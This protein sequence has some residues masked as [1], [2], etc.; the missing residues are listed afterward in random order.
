MLSCAQ[1]E[2]MIS[3]SALL[4]VSHS[5]R[6]LAGP[7]DSELSCGDNTKGGMTSDKQSGTS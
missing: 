3:C 1:F 2:E 7:E 4:V 5:H 6:L